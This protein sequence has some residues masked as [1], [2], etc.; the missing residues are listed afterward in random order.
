MSTHVLQ[1]NT[2]FIERFVKIKENGKSFDAKI[3]RQ[4]TGQN[5]ITAALKS[6]LE[7]ALRSCTGCQTKQCREAS[8]DLGQ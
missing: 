2:K 3:F 7:G 1:H 6:R 8:Q 5:L 4:Q